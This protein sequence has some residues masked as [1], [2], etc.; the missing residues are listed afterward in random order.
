MSAARAVTVYVDGV[1]DAL[2]TAAAITL[3]TAKV[4]V[5]HMI[6]VSETGGSLVDLQ[7]YECGLL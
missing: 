5:P 2:V 6:F 7:T 4:M 3:T 1:E